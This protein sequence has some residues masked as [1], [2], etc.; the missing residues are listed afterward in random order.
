[1]LQ[2]DGQPAVNADVGLVSPGA[3]LRLLPS[4]FNR[5]SGAY[6]RTLFN[7]DAN[8]RV[9]LHPDETVRKI[10]AV[11]A[12]GYAE[13]TP[14]MLQ[15]EP[16]LRLKSWGRIEGTYWASG[17][18][19]AQ[20]ELK[21]EFIDG[22]H[23]D[24]AFDFQAFRVTTDAQ[25][26][27]A[28]AKVPPVRLQLLRLIPSPAPDG[29]KSWGQ[30]SLIEVVVRPG[31]TTQ[32]ELGKSDRTVVL[33]LRWPDGW[34]LQ[35]GWRV[36]AL[37]CTPVPLPS[38]ELRTNQPALW[39]WQRRPENQAASASARFFPLKE[40]GDGSWKAEEV[41][42]GNYV[43]RAFVSDTNVPVGGDALRAR[44]EA[45][46]MVAEDSSGGEL[47]LGELPLQ[48]MAW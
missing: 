27:F 7:T 10:V 36:G 13:A 40:A 9:S 5:Q 42:P 48:P 17:Q 20:R 16:T 2:P 32:V 35:P 29:S 30:N 47:D 6:G 11:H 18:P 28:F 23:R 44:F 25:G 1:V 22:T 34:Q 3:Q 45:P 46:A 14:A 43:V 15:A 26:R 21:P 12:A 19:A 31:E 33:R 37:I 4:G 39:Q 38:R 8:G 24:M 41:A